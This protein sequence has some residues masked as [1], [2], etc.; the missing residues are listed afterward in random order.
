MFLSLAPLLKQVYIPNQF[1]EFP[2]WKTVISLK[3]VAVNLIQ[4]FVFNESFQIIN[5]RLKKYG[6]AYESSNLY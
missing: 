6:N 1:L 2:D 4:P 5:T 3:H